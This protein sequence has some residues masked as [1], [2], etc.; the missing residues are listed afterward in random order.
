MEQD[1]DRTFLV[2]RRQ[3]LADEGM[4][5]ALTVDQAPGWS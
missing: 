1:G 2:T 5:S 3:G 4:I